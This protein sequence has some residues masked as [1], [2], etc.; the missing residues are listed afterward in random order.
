ML[1]LIIQIG[2]TVGAWLRGWRLWALIPLGV[3]FVSGLIM[4][5]LGISVWSILSVGL[6]MDIVCTGVLVVMVIRPRP[7]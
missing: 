6:I 1:L 3:I 7:S 5:T 2:L 4:G